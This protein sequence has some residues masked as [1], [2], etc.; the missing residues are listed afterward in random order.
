MGK[1]SKPLQVIFILLALG[2]FFVAFEEISWGER[3]FNIEAPEVFD[4]GAL[5][6]LK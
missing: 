6:N 5:F 2:L 1:V 4:E 3:V